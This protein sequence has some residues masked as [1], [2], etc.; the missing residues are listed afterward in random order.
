M[1]TITVHELN[2]LAEHVVIDV[3]E[4]F[5]FANGHVPGAINIPL[6]LLLDKVDSLPDAEAL[7]VI[8]ASGGRS[9]QATQ[10]LARHGLN[11]VNV[12]DGTSAWLQ[13]GFPVER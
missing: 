1:K 7:Y 13:A 11:A 9:Q 3:R 2:S 8:C 12:D 10:F 5:E 6:S 4:P